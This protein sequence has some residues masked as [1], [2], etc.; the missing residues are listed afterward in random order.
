[1]VSKTPSKARQGGKP[2]TG[3][4]T[5]SAAHR[6]GRVIIEVSDDGGGIN[7]EK[8]RRIAEDKGLVAPGTTL[9]A[10][11]ID[12]LLFTPGFSSKDEVSALS[13]RGVG[14]DV[15]GARSRRLADGSRSN[16]RPARARPSPSPCH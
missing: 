14:L 12:N 5:L 16:R 11:E 10:G 1:M 13:G 7:R 15:V 3:T 6:S 4:I 8:V 2:E 9:T